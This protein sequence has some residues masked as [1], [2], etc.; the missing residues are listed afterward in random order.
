MAEELETVKGDPAEPWKRAVRHLQAVVS[1][2][3]LDRAL[4]VTLHFHPDRVFAGQQLIEHLA[5]DGV[6]RSQFETFTSNGGLTAHPGG[7]R[8]LWEHR[9]FGA[10]YDQAP[11]GARPKYGSLNHRRRSAG[12]SIRFGSAHLRLHEHTLHRSTFCY[13]DSV[14]NPTAFGT[15]DHM[16]LI[17]LA[18]ADDRD[19]LDDYIEAHLHGSLLLERDVEAVVLDPAYR[20]T[21][22]EVAAAALPFPVEWHPGFRLH[23][24][25]LLDHADY[26][27]QAVVTAGLTMATNGWL[28]ARIIGLAVRHDTYDH[29]T[30]KRLW[31]CVARFGGPAEHRLTEG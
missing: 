2:P 10:A 12:G 3:R 16:G 27:G 14:F 11:V 15:A 1:G 17:P 22:I 23:I 21:D 30:L 7:D 20:G 29:Q 18:D 9:I 8:W 13:P 6:Y 25:D 24:D 26:R 28:D 5:G 31:H 4:R 19:L